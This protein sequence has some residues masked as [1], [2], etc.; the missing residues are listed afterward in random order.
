M[1]SLTIGHPG[2]YYSIQS[3]AMTEAEL[4]ACVWITACNY[5][6]AYVLF[7]FRSSL[8]FGSLLDVFFWI[9]AFVSILDC[10]FLLVCSS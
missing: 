10:G 1:H 6:F 4:A 3:H 5:I 9:L 8:E 2:L 7:Q